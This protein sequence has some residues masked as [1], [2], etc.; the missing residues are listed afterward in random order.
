MYRKLRGRHF[1][2]LKKAL[3]DF[4]H[5]QKEKG[6]QRYL[7]KAKRCHCGKS[8]A[9]IVVLLFPFDRG[10]SLTTPFSMHESACH[11]ASST[12]FR[13]VKRRGYENV[14]GVWGGQFF[15]VVECSIF[16]AFYPDLLALFMFPSILS[17]EGFFASSLSKFQGAQ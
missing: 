8:L 14:N 7:P 11:V 13:K 3:L 4:V 6:G 10:R 15:G 5:D 2:A 16:Y 12:S 9:N 17:L 1:R